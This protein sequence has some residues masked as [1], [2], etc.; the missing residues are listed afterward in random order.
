MTPLLASFAFTFVFCLSIYVL[1]IWA[2]SGLNKD[3]EK[4]TF[5]AWRDDKP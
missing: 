5:G 2:L 4:L 3:A 1:M